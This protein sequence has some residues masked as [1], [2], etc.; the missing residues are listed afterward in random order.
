MKSD[1]KDHRERDHR[2]TE[3]VKDKHTSV[4]AIPLE[5]SPRPGES[6]EKM[7]KRFT[8]KVRAD[9]ILREL[10]TRKAYEKPSVKRRRK[11]A[12]ARFNAMIAAREDERS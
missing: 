2:P 6:P 4:E 9:G 8:R 1:Y 3:R 7:I 12:Q 11:A 10:Y 5:V